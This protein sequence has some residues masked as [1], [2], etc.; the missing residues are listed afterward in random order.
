MVEDGKITKMIKPV[1][2][3]GYGYDILMKISMVANDL[4]IAPG[5]CG[6]ASGSCFVSVGQ[7]TLL[8]SQIL[9]GGKG[10]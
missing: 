3:M 5:V 8:V 2:L 6:A 1:T 10:E 7:P 4:K 9:V